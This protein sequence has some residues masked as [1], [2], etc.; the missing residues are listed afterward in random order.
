MD[1]ASVASAI[2]GYNRCGWL[3]VRERSFTHPFLPVER[4]DSGGTINRELP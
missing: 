1:A 3:F 2:T 4:I